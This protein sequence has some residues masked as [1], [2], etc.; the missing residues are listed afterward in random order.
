MLDANNAPTGQTTNITGLEQYR[1]ALMNLP[2]GTATTYQLT[3]GSAIVPL[4]LWRLAL[5]AEDVIKLTPQLTASAGL[6]YALQT[7][8]E[9]SANFGPRLSLSWSPDKKQAWILHARA[10][11][12]ESPTDAAA[13]A[14]VARLN[15]IRQQEFTTYSAAYS[16]GATSAPATG[17]LSISTVNQFESSLAQSS[18]FNE[19]SYLPY[20]GISDRAMPEA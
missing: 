4:T 18:T 16:S 20:A 7:N 17:L 8:P 14:E 19:G 6:R 13:V 2:G 10:G 11:L 12:F 15:G 5:Y 1:R 9:N 3:S